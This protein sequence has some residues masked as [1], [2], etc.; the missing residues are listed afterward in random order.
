M[1]TADIAR[2][3]FQMTITHNRSDMSELNM[4]LILEQQ[5]VE[6]QTSVNDQMGQQMRDLLVELKASCLH[7][8]ICLLTCLLAA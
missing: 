3:H 5:K 6:R 1:H 4:K 7:W 2:M 8:L